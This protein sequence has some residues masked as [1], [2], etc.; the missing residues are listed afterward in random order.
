MAQQLFAKLPAQAANG[1]DITVALGVVEGEGSTDYGI[2]RADIVSVAGVAHAV[3]TAHDV[4]F[5][6]RTVRAGVAT[7]LAVWDLTTAALVAEIP[8]SMLPLAATAIRP[9]DGDVI[10]VLVHQGSTGTA[11][12][13]SDVT[14]EVELD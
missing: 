6:L 10:D 4:T 14:V 2:L 11:L 1:A 8:M 13:V 12:L 3:D 9:K 7:V 5:S